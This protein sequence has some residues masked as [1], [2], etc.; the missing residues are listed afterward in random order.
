MTFSTFKS[1]L[2]KLPYGKRLNH[3]VYIIEES[4]AKV[5]E[6][7]TEEQ[8]DFIDMLEPLNI[9]T[10]YPTYKEQLFTVLMPVLIYIAL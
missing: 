5:D 10:R 7:L 3:A 9:E 4:L 2:E 6:M 1:R 8:K